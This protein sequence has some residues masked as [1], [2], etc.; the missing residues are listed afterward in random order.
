MDIKKKIHNEIESFTCPFDYRIAT[1]GTTARDSLSFAVLPRRS[2]LGYEAINFLVISPENAKEVFSLLDHQVHYVFVDIESKK[3]IKLMEIARQTIRKARIVSYKPN[4][5][6]LEAADLFLRHYFKDDIEGKNILIYGAGNLGSKLALRL[7]ER[8]GCVFL[9]S[10]NEEKTKEII[11]V[12][13]Y[14]L[15][16]FT[17]NKINWVNLSAE[18]EVQLDCLISFTS[19]SHVIPPEFSR[20]LKE[21]ALALD[22]GINNFTPQFILKAGERK[23]I[24]YRLDVRAAFPHSVLFLVPY[25]QEFYSA[26]Q[27]EKKLNGRTRLVAGGV[28]GNEGDIVADRIQNPTQI[29]G[30]ANGVGGLKEEKDYTGE[31][32]KHVNSLLQVIKKKS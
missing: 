9:N 13:N 20:F 28:I 7:A 4:D 26:I 10:R 17:N 8:G 2:A 24:S 21:G 12:L 16:K 1:V 25:I 29:V 27:G 14:L 23:I 22:G 5:T 32:V 15:P 11:K 6:T 19:S 18:P 3:D 30:V 31:D